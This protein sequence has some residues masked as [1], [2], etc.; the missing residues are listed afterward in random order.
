LL[1]KLKHGHSYIQYSRPGPADQKGVDFDAAGHLAVSPFDRIGVP[2]D[3]RFYLC[4]PPAFMRQ[5]TAG[6]AAWGVPVDHIHTEIFGTLDSITPGLKAETHS[7]H[8]PAGPTGLGP[9]VSFARS[10]LTLPWNAKY[11]SLLEL[12]EACDVPVRWSCRTGVCHT[13]ETAL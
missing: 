5:L 1:Q 6:L 13:C 9:Q 3:G 4:G 11:G 12:A 10:G 8:L 7:P 2:H